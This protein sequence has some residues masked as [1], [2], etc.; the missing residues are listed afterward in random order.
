MP[1]KVWTP[2]ERQA[3]G[4]K[5]K[6]RREEKQKEREAQEG[7]QSHSEPQT[8][9][10]QN[11]EEPQALPQVEASKPQLEEPSQ[12]E[13]LKRVKELESYLFRMVGNQTQGQQSGPQISTHGGIQGTL[14]KYSVNPK[15]YPD[16]RDRLF[17]EPRLILQNFNRTWWDLEFEVTSVNYQTKDGINIKEP[18]FQLKLIRIIADPDTEE[19]SNKRY[20]LH[21]ATFFEDPQAA[22]DVANQHGLKVAE[23]LE[24][25]FLDEMRYLRMRDWLLES[26]YL[27]KPDSAKQK[28][29]EQ[30]IENRLVKV[31]EHSSQNAESVPFEQLRNKK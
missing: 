16:P 17:E 28:V 31:Y 24:K 26:F 29:T 8:P 3:F 7:T 22:I 21:K 18:K 10:S 27:P 19:P 15:D 20:V 9:S 14:V 23:E 4:E 11:V 2:E 6:A 1:K 25:A 12:D 5:M 30:V 13:L